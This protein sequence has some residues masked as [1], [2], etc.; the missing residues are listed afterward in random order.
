MNIQSHEVTVTVKKRQAGDHALTITEDTQGWT[1]SVPELVIARSGKFHVLTHAPS[2]YAIVN[3]GASWYDLYHLA[4]QL[5]PFDWSSA[6]LYETQP[7]DWD[8]RTEVV[9]A[10]YLATFHSDDSD[11]ATVTIRA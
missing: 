4:E 11:T 8:Q 9:R 3:K 7:N 5:A 10:W 1:T 2:G 6:D